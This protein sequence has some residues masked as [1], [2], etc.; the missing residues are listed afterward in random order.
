MIKHAVWLDGIAWYRFLLMFWFEYGKNYFLYFK[1]FKKYLLRKV[2]GSL[3][4]IIF[5]LVGVY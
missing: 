3:F 2:L 5:L 1:I 4:S